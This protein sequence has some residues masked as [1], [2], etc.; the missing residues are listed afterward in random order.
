MIKNYM[1]ILVDEILEEIKY[2]YK[3]CNEEACINHVKILVLNQLPPA[4][5]LLHVDE[6]IGKAF[7]LDRQRRI[8][9]LAKVAE[10]IDQVC[11]GCNYK[12]D[13]I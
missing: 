1:E 12:K 4:Y 8:S 13:E 5:F 2:T 11:N 7:L 9:V 6:A 10:A 3:N